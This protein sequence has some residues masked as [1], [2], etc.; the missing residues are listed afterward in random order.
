M[1]VFAAAAAAWAPVAGL[2]LFLVLAPLAPTAGVAA[3]Y[4]GEADPT[5][6]LTLAAP[7]SKARLLLLRTAIVVATCVPLTMLAAVPLSGPWW[8]AVVWLLPAAAFVLVTLAATTYAPPVYAATGVAVLWVAAT[9]P[10]LLRREPLAL[11][12]STALT[13]V[14][15]DRPGRRTGLP[16]PAPP[17]CHRLE[18]RMNPTAELSG[19]TQRFRSTTALDGVSLTLRPGHH[20]ARS[21]PTAPARPPCCASRRPCWP[22]TPAASGSSVA[23][24]P[25]CPS[26]PRCAA[27]WATCRRSSASPGAS[28]RSASSTTWRC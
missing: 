3:A 7:Y 5:H 21:G 4:G 23:T 11:L 14:R 18:D 20:G 6:E 27:G 17:S 2:G 10:A 19:V 1:L 13:G 25:P 24:W 16:G 26:G 12:D 28:P 9:F 22:P 8:V 15:G